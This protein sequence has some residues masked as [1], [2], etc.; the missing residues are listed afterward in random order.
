MSS[1]KGLW[2]VP[3][4]PSAEALGFLVSR[5]GRSSVAAHLLHADEKT[6]I[7]GTGVQQANAD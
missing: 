1:L 7:S 2:I 5:P 4:L 3:P 6:L